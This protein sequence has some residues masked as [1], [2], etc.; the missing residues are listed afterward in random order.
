[1]PVSTLLL[2]LIVLIVL[3]AAFG[4]GS[5]DGRGTNVLWIV[6]LILFIFW[7]LSQLGLV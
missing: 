1:M 2:V 3:L 6:A 4:R 7:L 5:I